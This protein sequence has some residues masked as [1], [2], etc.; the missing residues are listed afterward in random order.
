MEADGLMHVPSPSPSRGSESG[1]PA[2]T[3]S[4]L[5]WCRQIHVRTYESKREC[6]GLQETSFALSSWVSFEDNG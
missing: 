3:R 2:Y 1:L 6:R 5:W 4:N